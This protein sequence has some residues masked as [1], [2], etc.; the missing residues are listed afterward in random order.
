MNRKQKSE[1]R[2]DE[3]GERGNKGLTREEKITMR[4]GQRDDGC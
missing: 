2:T 1:M 3:I 4:N